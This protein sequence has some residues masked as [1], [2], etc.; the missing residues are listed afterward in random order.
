MLEDDVEAE[1]VVVVLLLFVA[2]EAQEVEDPMCYLFFVSSASF[3]IIANIAR[4]TPENRLRR[5]WKALYS[6]P[7]RVLRRPRQDAEHQLEA[8]VTQHNTSR[9]MWDE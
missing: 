7:N 2:D 6:P 9:S 4:T 1:G 3:G 8:R 5:R